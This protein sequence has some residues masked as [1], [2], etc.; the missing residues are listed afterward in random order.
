MPWCLSLSLSLTLYLSVS[1]CHLCVSMPQ[2]MSR[3]CLSFFFLPPCFPVSQPFSLESDVSLL[4]CPAGA[5]LRSSILPTR[6]NGCRLPVKHVVAAKGHEARAI[7]VQVIGTDGTAVRRVEAPQREGGASVALHGVKVR[8]TME[9]LV[10]VGNGLVRVCQHLRRDW[11]TRISAEM[12]SGSS[13]LQRTSSGTS[14][15]ST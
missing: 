4:L 8:R 2:A 1:V 10:H 5:A 9:P 6:L 13:A 12:Q 7:G 15:E 3:V 14:S 11:V